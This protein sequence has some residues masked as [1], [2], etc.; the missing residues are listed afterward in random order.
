MRGYYY[1][2][3]SVVKPGFKADNT[4]VEV[5]NYT[6]EN[7]RKISA[8]DDERYIQ[9]RHYGITPVAGPHIMDL[10]SKTGSLS[11]QRENTVKTSTRGK[12]SD[13]ISLLRDL[14][15]SMSRKDRFRE[16]G[17]EWTYTRSS[18]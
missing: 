17:G 16:N 9:L 14:S 1:T 6:A 15:S 18:I 8:A 3:A 10:L 4:D 7:C 11:G 12:K 5:D 2:S 13:T